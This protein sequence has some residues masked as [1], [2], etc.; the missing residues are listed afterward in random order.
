MLRPLLSCPLAI[1]AAGAVAAMSAG[2]ALAQSST[3]QEAQKFMSERASIVQGL[4]KNAGKDKKLDPRYACSAFGK[5][6]SNGETGLTWFDA[7]KEWCSVPDQVVANFKKEHD[8]VK[9]LRGQ[10]CGAV[11]KMEKMQQQ[12]KKGPQNGNPFGGGLTG[13]YRIPQGAM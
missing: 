11:A 13:E 2:P 4:N 3:C 1:A 6:V 12:A 10:A 8:K 5:L 9:D 7:N